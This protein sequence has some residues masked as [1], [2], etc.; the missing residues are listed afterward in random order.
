MFLDGEI[1]FFI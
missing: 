1:L